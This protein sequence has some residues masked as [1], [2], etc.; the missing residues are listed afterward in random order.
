MFDIV[1]SSAR[2]QHMD[3]VVFGIS[4]RPNS[5]KQF[6]SPAFRV[7]IE[8]VQDKEC[9]LSNAV[10]GRMKCCQQYLSGRL[11]T[12]RSIFRAHLLHRNW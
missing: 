11:M 10:N 5:S 9:L 12:R 2:H 4:K 7:F 3:V 1:H 6:L 8:G